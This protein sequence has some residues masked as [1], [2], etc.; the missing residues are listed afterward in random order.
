MS[1]AIERTLRIIASGGGRKADAESSN[2]VEDL[3]S[4]DGLLDAYSR[5]VVGVVDRVGPAVVSISVRKGS[6]RRGG[7]GEGAGS[8]VV[9]APDGYILTNSHVVSGAQSLRI[10]VTDGRTLDAEIV[11][12]DPATD[13]AVIRGSANGLE[14]AE[15]GH[16][17][18]L[19]V[20]QLVI[21]IGN[22]LGFQNTV[23][24]GVVSGVGRTLRGESGRL[25]ENVI[26]TDAPLNPGNSGGPLVD[27][28]GRV[29]GINTAVILGAQGLSFAVPVD[30][31][32][33][34]VTELLRHGK[35]LRAFLGIGG[36]TRPLDRRRQRRFDIEAETAVEVVSV[37][38][39]GPA[40]RADVHHDDLIVTLDGRPIATVD[41]LH[42]ALASLA[43]GADVRLGIIR[44]GERRELEVTLDEA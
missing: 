10:S 29:V 17:D 32:K 43:S 16:S 4:D 13:L 27:S 42:R 1:D 37:E 38:R 11:G 23:S 20:G 22:P 3:P 18:R 30:T 41:D 28:R 31:A 9:I 14:A 36:Q 6:G 25:I 35:V 5:A 26:Q 34:V 40:H 21:A 33:W 7:R 2:G 19:R 12:T 24:T 8:G 44:Q 39:D 15:L